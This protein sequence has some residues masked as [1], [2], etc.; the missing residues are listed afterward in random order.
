M[1]KFIFAL[2]AA[3]SVMAASAQTT[4]KVEAPN[5]VGVNEQFNVRFIISGEDGPSEFHWEPGGDFQLVWGPQKGTSSST[6]Y[7]NGTRT[8]TAQT[9]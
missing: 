4:I 9:S 2:I 1:R 6:R 8:H 7:V 5:I 3:F